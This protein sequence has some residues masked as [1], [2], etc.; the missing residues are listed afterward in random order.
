MFSSSRRAIMR[1]FLEKCVSLLTNPMTGFR[2]RIGALP[3]FT[4]SF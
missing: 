3:E 4:N 2:G 1:L